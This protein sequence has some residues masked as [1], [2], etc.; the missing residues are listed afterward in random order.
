[1][2]PRTRGPARGPRPAPDHGP[3]R[4][5]EGRPARPSRPPRPGAGR[6]RLPGQ[7]RRRADARPPRLIPC[8][9]GSNPEDPG[10]AG[11]AAPSMSRRLEW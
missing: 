3:A 5:A 6:H 9:R 8:F 4:R 11:R 2:G 7:R 10:A 1:A